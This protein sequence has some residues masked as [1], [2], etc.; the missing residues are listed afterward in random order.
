MIN[1]KIILTLLGYGFGL[2]ASCSDDDVS[3]TDIDCRGNVLDDV[4]EE[5][6]RILK[7]EYGIIPAKMSYASVKFSRKPETV[8]LDN[9]Y[10]N[11][12]NRS[13]GRKKFYVPRV[14]GKINTS[15][16]FGK[17]RK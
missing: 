12:P 14:M 17:Y 7:E 6:L 9:L 2:S 1:R 13:F 4:S 8:N 11:N 16:K 10:F 5:E 15:P 3:L